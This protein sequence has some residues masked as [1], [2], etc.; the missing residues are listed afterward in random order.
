MSTNSLRNL[1][2]FKVLMLLGC[3]LI[4]AES[5]L[6]LVANAH[7]G[8]EGEALEA[9]E[10]MLTPFLTL[11]AH[12]GRENSKENIPEHSG[13]DAL[14]GAG[15]DWGLENDGMFSIQTGVGPTAVW[16]EADHFYNAVHEE[17]EGEE[18]EKHPN[19]YKRIDYR[20]FLKFTYKPNNRTAFSLDT[21]AHQITKTEGE[22]KQ[23]T[24]HEIGAK[25]LYRFGDGDVDFA[26]GDQFT[27]LI[28]GTYFSLEHR[29]GWESTG[30]W[31][32]KYTDPRLGVEFNYDE[33]SFK[34]EGGPRFYRPRYDAG[35]STRTDYSGEVEVSVPVSE[36]AEFFVHWQPTFSDKDGSEWNKAVSHH[37]GAGMTFIF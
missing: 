36:N 33:V 23:G 3:S 29:Q 15:L 17:E 37:V 8:A 6:P 12:Y 10:F 18:H 4:S 26:L 28:D 31:Q 24:K 30:K 5:V 34:I 35:L 13:Y 22:E 11:E 16:G 25:A 27:D 14:F 32:G 9:G 20:G 21:K 1:S 2:P 19:E 7:G